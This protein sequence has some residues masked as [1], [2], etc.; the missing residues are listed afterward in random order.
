MPSSND[1]MTLWEHLDELRSTILKIL[2]VLAVTT[3]LLFSFMP[4]IFDSVIMAPCFS[5]FPLYRLFPG[6]ENWHVELINIQLSSQFF[7]HVSTSFWL[8]LVLSMPLCLYLLWQFVAPGLYAKEKRGATRAFALGSVLFFLGVAVGYFVVFPITLRFLATYQVSQ[9]IPNQISLDSYIGTFMMLIFIMGAVFELPVAAWMLSAAG[10]L[11]KRHISR[12]RR[13]SI[14]A[15]LVVAAII[16]PTGDPFT[17]I[18][19][20]A[21]IYLLYEFSAILVKR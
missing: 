3:A 15:I 16:T 13:H 12:Y 19:V 5:D 1:A 11:R 7:V 18:V 2:A 6:S 14:V 4:T 9:Y 8:A 21:P 20:S 17:L 10:V